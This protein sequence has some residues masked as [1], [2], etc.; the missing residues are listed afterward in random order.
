M[1]SFYLTLERHSLACVHLYRPRSLRPPRLSSCGFPFPGHPSPQPCLATSYSSCKGDLDVSVGERPWPF[2]P[3]PP[4]VHPSCAPSSSAAPCVSI[5]ATPSNGFCSGPS[6][7]LS[8]V[9]GFI[10]TRPERRVATRCW[11]RG[12]GQS[13][14]RLPINEPNQEAHGDSLQSGG[15]SWTLNLKP[16]RWLCSLFAGWQEEVRPRL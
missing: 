4:L 15:D 2:S 12:T 5:P 14:A 9:T 1:F 10:S 16:P 11:H 6:D 3:S 13:G 8:A 7:T